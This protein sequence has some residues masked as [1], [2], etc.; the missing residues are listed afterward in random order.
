M[1]AMRHMPFLRGFSFFLFYVLPLFIYHLCFEHLLHTKH[2]SKCRR[3]DSDQENQI[4]EV[5]AL[6]RASPFGFGNGRKDTSPHTCPLLDGASLSTDAFAAPHSISPVTQSL[7]RES[8]FGSLPLVY[9]PLSVP[10]VFVC[11]LARGLCSFLYALPCTGTFSLICHTVFSVPW[12]SSSR[13]P[14][15]ENKS[16]LAYYSDFF[17]DGDMSFVVL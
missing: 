6:S 10:T 2:C 12:C 13:P 11:S 17:F 5:L 15:L 7:S 8:V 9:L 16:R 1:E 4:L 3:L 14:L